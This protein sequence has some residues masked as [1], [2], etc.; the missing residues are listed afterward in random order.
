MECNTGGGARQHDSSDLWLIDAE[1]KLDSMLAS[2]AP[3][4][5]SSL[6]YATLKP[7][8]DQ[9]LCRINTIPKDIQGADAVLD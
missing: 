9:F 6:S 3:V 8:R 7:F 2:H 5:A 1:T 4:A